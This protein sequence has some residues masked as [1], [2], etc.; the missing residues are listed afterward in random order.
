MAKK[1]HLTES[2]LTRII[3]KVINES[4]QPINEQGT[5]PTIEGIAHSL[6]GMM[7]ALGILVHSMEENNQ[8]LHEIKRGERVDSEGSKYNLQNK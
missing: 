6:D 4:K 3:E 1:I 8:L 2:D 7:H 5:E